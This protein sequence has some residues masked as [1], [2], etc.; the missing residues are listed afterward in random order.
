MDYAYVTSWSGDTADTGG[1]TFDFNTSSVTANYL[2]AADVKV[3]Q[4]SLPSESDFA[5]TR[6]VILLSEETIEKLRLEGDPVGQRVTLS[7][8]DGPDD[9]TIVGVLEGSEWGNN[10]PN[11]FVPHKPAP[12]ETD[13]TSLTGAEAE[14]GTTKDSSTRAQPRATTWIRPKQ[15]F[16]RRKKRWRAK[17]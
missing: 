12:W 1:D 6:R 7:S 15:R 14:L 9:Y 17:R 11:T 16:H 10:G 3:I 2:A 4:G 8:F 5:G 13:G